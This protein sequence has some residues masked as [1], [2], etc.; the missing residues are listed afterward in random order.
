MLQRI[1]LTGRYSCGDAEETRLLTKVSYGLHFL[2]LC[3][4][5]GTQQELLELD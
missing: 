2:Q 5:S 3:G 1:H 4:R